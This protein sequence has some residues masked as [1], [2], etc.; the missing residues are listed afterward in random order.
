MSHEMRFVVRSSSGS[1]TYD[2]FVTRT[3]TGIRFA[4][5]CPAADNG[6]HCK[7]RV[8]L[9]LGDAKMLVDGAPQDVARLRDLF[10]PSGIYEALTAI[11]QLERDV[12][13]AKAQIAVMKR[14]VA[15]CMMG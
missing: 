3:Q 13:T 5:S 11:Q 8:A 10:R 6:T 12:A 1:G 7:H 9:L 14:Q 4:C 15:E 2:L